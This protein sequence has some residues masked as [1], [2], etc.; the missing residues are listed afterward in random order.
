[1]T[2]SDG[3]PWV[4]I[5]GIAEAVYTADNG[6]VVGAIL[7]DGITI[8]L[9]VN[10]DDT[11]AGILA[12]R[13]CG[14]TPGRHIV[15]VSAKQGGHDF[16]HVAEMTLTQPDERGISSG[17]APLS[18]PVSHPGTIWFSVN[19]DGQLAGR[20]PFTVWHKLPRP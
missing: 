6:Q 17:S 7:F 1:M 11:T 2:V 15:E 10:H 8:D 16:G 13:V 18:I 3:G 5:A 12:L 9:A 4:M 20:F 19:I 14:G